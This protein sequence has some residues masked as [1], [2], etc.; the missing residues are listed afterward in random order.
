MTAKKNA[1]S[2]LRKNRTQ[3]LAFTQHP[4]A[5]L[6]LEEK[7]LYL[8]MLALASTMNGEFH[9]P[10]GSFLEILLRT[11]GLPPEEMEELRHYALEPGEE[12]LE[13][14]TQCFKNQ[15]KALPF[16]LDL[17]EILASQEIP[18]EEK[19]DFFREMAL[20]LQISS[21][22]TKKIMETHRRVAS[23][24]E[25]IK[26]AEIPL[27]WKQYRHL[28]ECRALQGDLEGQKAFEK[29]EGKRRRKSS[30]PLLAA[31]LHT[32]EHSAAVNSAVFSPQGTQILTVSW[33]CTS[34]LWN[35]ETG[36]ELLS[37]NPG[38]I[39]N[40]AVFSPQG[41]S[42]LTAISDGNYTARLW[43]A[44]TGEERLSLNHENK[45][46]YAVFSPQ[47]TSILTASWDDTA[48]LWD[49]ETGEE[50]L[51]LNHESTVNS[52]VFSPCGT[53]ILTASCD[54]T[55][56]LWDAETGEELLSLNHEYTVNSA[57]FSPQ[58]TQILTA[59]D[60][61]AAKLWN[62]ETGEE[63]LS[64]NHEG[65]VNSAVFSPCGTQ[66]LTASDD[67]TAKLWDAETGELLYS[68]EH[69]DKVKSALFSP[70][71]TQILTG[72]MDGKA[73]LWQI[74]PWGK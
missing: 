15:E 50:L 37:L 25:D 36:E 44:E 66:I 71:G 23:A 45:V 58:G 32:F 24:D 60:G 53:Q 19:E 69:P 9:S 10:E 20:T 16:L 12:S 27:P 14:F 5:D 4:A 72:C 68:I 38:G 41:T 7:N 46:P 39:A 29:M 8:R 28:L 59:S 70:D 13:E 47:G 61:F 21:E 33:D 3:N 2:M 18:E 48:K 63:L 40:S 35:V 17:R 74:I 6:P 52:A 65:T 26:A 64:L 43:N 30:V 34:K 54:S 73:R 1:L 67:G 22:A 56:K 62:A 42:I 57:V 49:A 31:K 55:A 11:F 51:S